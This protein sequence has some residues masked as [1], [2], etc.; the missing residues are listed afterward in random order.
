MYLFES[1]HIDVTTL[2][3]MCLI[4]KHVHIGGMCVGMGVYCM[5]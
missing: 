3:M 4:L 2:L 1:Q 5:W